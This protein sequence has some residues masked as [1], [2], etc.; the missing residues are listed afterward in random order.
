V[1]SKELVWVLIPAYNEEA[2]I[3][4][5]VSELNSQ[6]FAGVVVVNDGSTDQTSR[7]AGESGAIVLDHVINQGVGAAIRTGLKYLEKKGADWGLQVDGDGQHDLKSINQMLSNDSFD[8]VIGQRDWTKYQ[9]GLFRKMAQRALLFI[10]RANGVTGINDPTSG[11]RLF[12]NN[13]IKL[14]SREMPSNFLGDTVEAL[15]ISKRHSHSI[16]GVT[17][18]MS[19]RA[20][21]Q[22]SHSGSRIVR[23]FASALLYSISYFPRRS[24]ND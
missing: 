15:I 6:S 19:P 23:A 10:L 8:L 12:S 24:K 4:S 13:S 1:I 21:G 17:V 22:S 2:A 11:F 16:G 18:L 9:F 20:F 3:G 7:V 5:I 14:L